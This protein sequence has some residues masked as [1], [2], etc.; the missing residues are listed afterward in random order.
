MPPPCPPGPVAASH[1]ARARRQQR[2]ARF[3]LAALCLLAGVSV[4]ARAADTWTTPFPGVRLLKRVTSTPWRIFALEVDLCARGVSTRA[5]KST[6]KKRT[7][8][9]FRNLVDAQ[10]AING[11]FFSYT[12][13][14]PSGL[15]MGDG[16]VWHNDNSSRGYVALGSDRSI[17]ALQEPVLGDPSAWMKEA[18][19]GYPIL[20][21]DG[22]TLTSFPIAP[23]HC[24]ERHPRTVVGLTR[25]RQ[26][27]L[28]VIVDGRTDLSVGMTCKELSPLMVELGAW[29]ALN[30]DGGGSSAL[31]LEGVGAVNDPS[32]G[33]ERVVSNHLAVFA[34]GSGAPASCD[35]WMDQ[36]IVE[37]GL[38][39]EGQFTDV[40]GDGR[41]DLCARAS[42]GFRCYVASG[43]GFSTSGWPIADLSDA[44]GFD[45]ESR[46][47]TIRMADVT[48]DGLADVCARS[49]SG[50]SCWPSTGTGFGAAL[51]GPGWSDASGWSQPQYFSTIRLADVTGD[52]AADVCARA[53]A[54]I[55]C[56]SLT[57]G[58]AL[59]NGPAW[60]DA[61]G[62]AEPHRHGSIRFADISGDGRADVCGLGASGLVCSLSTGSGFGPELAGPAWSGLSD[63]AYWGSFRMPDLNND[64]RA[65]ACV[66]L[67]SGVACAL[68]TGS[69]F[70]PVFAGPGFTDDSGWSDLAN[71]TSLR[72]GDLDGDGDADLCARANIGV[73]CFPY[74]GSAF[75]AKIVGPAFAESDGWDDFRH[76]SSLKLADIN[77]DGR[78]DICGREPAG[79]TCALSQGDAFAP[80]V[81]VG[82]LADASGW[83]ATAYGST[84]RLGGVSC[85]SA[86][87]LCDGVDDDCDGDTD[88]DAT[89]TATSCG[90]GSCAG[91]G[92]LVCVDGV[93]TDTCSPKPNGAGCDDGDPCTTGESCNAGGCANGA[94]KSCSDGD[95]CTADSCEPGVGCVYEPLSGC[96]AEDVS[97]PPPDEPDVTATPDTNLAPDVGTAAHDTTGDPDAGV[98]WPDSHDPEPP[99]RVAEPA[100]GGA[101]DA[102]P[103]FTAPDS[104]DPIERPGFDTQDPGDLSV[105]TEV[106]PGGGGCSM[107]SAVV[108]APPHSVLVLLAAAIGGLFRL[109][110]RRQR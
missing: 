98:A 56:K 9:S 22:Q 28:L 34:D 72:F 51:T 71:A 85:P 52:G 42:A 27:L 45:V 107:D 79:V 33:S 70:G 16:T 104:A 102:G 74:V 91:S 57:A 106:I 83:A 69:G 11:D 66:R 5:T 30:L 54:G 31:S 49:A 19:G 99:G 43:T 78:A 95:P 108:G 21:K 84:L 37:A 40:N 75:G 8:S 7:T 87:D 105:R 14:N 15:A 59:L 18:V 3:W 39:D 6:E 103:W 62:W 73:S 55:Q 63:V 64:G 77:G 96:P 110:R 82:M 12:D 46:F 100:E 68:S 10:A 48:G 50:V 38:L 41:A 36:V 58:S 25:D 44:A 29:T 1:G 65:D 23:S 53:G 90:A 20:V 94:A 24:P 97:G 13:Y 60:S 88:E 80:L 61:A 2:G 101:P 89:S 26:K 92:A 93:V 76:Y 67:A 86:A 4:D 47:A 32:D 81:P 17:I 109:G 35:L